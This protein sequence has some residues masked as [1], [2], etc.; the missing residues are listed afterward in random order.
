MRI[1]RCCFR[2]RKASSA[3]W[4]DNC[5]T[6]FN[7]QIVRFT[8]L[9][10]VLQLLVHCKSLLVELFLYTFATTLS[11][12]ST[13]YYDTAQLLFST[14]CALDLMI[15]SSESIAVSRIQV[16]DLT[17]CVLQKK[18]PFILHMNIKSWVESFISFPFF[19][20][21]NT[22]INYIASL[23]LKWEFVVIFQYPS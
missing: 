14:K 17:Q 22:L 12:T 16:Q 13:T 3:T 9:V 5:K 23:G 1:W 7:R 8:D 10:R 2:R 15:L 18:L 11:V 21:D 20:S 6:K 4:R 19:S